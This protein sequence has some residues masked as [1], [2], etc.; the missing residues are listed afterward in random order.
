MH[1]RPRMSNAQMSRWLAPYHPYSSVIPPHPCLQT[2]STPKG[3]THV[4]WRTTPPWRQHN[5]A[6]YDVG[7]PAPGHKGGMLPDGAAHTSQVCLLSSIC[8]SPLTMQRPC[9]ASKHAISRLDPR[10]D[11]SSG[12]RRMARMPT[13]L[14]RTRRGSTST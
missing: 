5:E 3:P 14:S 11:Q 1:Q 2:A 9:T 7:S 13:A 12:L 10:M 4:G 6:T 8:P